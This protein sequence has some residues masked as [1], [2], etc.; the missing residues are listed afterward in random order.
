MQNLPISLPLILLVLVIAAAVSAMVYAWAGGRQR[1]EILMRV[2]NPA[3]GSPLPSPLL[4]APS[5][6]FGERFAE[7]LADR[8]PESLTANA[9]T[10][11]KLVQAGFES[12]SAAVVYGAVRVVFGILVP[13]AVFVA[14]AGSPQKTLLL[15][16]TFGAMIGLLGPAAVLDRFVQ[17]RQDKLRKAVPDALDLL[18]V[19]V[20]A[21]VSLD[22]AILRVARDLSVTHPELAEEMMVI[23]RKVNAG[24]P[25][26][27]ALN[28]LWSRTGLEEL[29]GLAASMIQSERWGT[30]IAKVLRVNAETLRRKR[31][32]YAEKKAA[33][34]SLKMMGP[35]LLFLLPAL[36]VVILG[37]AAINISQAFK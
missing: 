22:A 26:E 20:E 11:T 28:G 10:G 17:M 12:D 23:N 34:A 2:E 14:A 6:T 32:Q 7:W 24:I 8:T 9:Q 5:K 31:K 16:V 15:Y 4:S 21:G 1:R 19:C 27:A 13:L 18:V 35:L 36:F 30:S 25:R 37:P 3:L 29:R 33:Q